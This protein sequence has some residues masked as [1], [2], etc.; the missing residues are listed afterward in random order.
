M[1]R[2]ARIQ[3][4]ARAGEHFVAAELNRRGVYAVTFAGNMPKIDILAS[5]TDQTRTVSIQVKTR[6]SGTWQTSTTEGRRCKRPSDQTNFWIFVDIEKADQPP[7]YYIV[8]EWWIRNDIYNSH[9]AYL[10]KHGGKRKFNPKSTHHS[11]YI[12]RIEQWKDR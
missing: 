3:Q 5:N 4:T 6:R 10:K 8:P 12:K 7:G 11:I 2:G 1:A 9:E